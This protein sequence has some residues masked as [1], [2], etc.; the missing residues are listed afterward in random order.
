MLKNENF[1]LEKL[2]NPGE[3]CCTS[4]GS[5]IKHPDLLQNL[6]GRHPRWETLKSKLLHGCD[7]PVENLAENVRLLDLKENLSRG[8]HK[9]AKRNEEHLGKSNKDRN[10]ER[11][12]TYTPRRISTPHP[13]FRV[14]SNGSGGSPWH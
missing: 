3:T 5:E 6:L 13:G 10:R 12:G 11:M 2:L 1:N 7:Y 8:N 4:Y 14:R 9:S